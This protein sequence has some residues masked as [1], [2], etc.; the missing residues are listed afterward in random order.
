MT[1]I[2]YLSLF[3]STQILR[4]RAGEIEDDD[5]G[6]TEKVLIGRA[7]WRNEMHKASTAAGAVFSKEIPGHIRDDKD[8]SQLEEKPIASWNMDDVRFWLRT[9]SSAIAAR[10]FDA[11]AAA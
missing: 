6:E 8:R 5:E 9:V 4:V 11:D 7:S 1:S 2:M 10:W 3:L